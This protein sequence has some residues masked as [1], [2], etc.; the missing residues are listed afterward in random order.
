MSD[1]ISRPPFKQRLSV[2][3][4]FL[5]LESSGQ[6]CLCENVFVRSSHILSTPAAPES[7][8]LSLEHRA[9]PAGSGSGEP[10]APLGGCGPS[11]RALPN[12]FSQSRGPC[13]AEVSMLSGRLICV[14]GCYT[15]RNAG[16]ARSAHLDLRP[17]EQNCASRP[18]YRSTSRVKR[19][20][21]FR[22]YFL[23]IG[24]PSANAGLINVRVIGISF[25]IDAAWCTSPSISLLSCVFVL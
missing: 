13:S 24:S 6:S 11:E 22:V 14:G 3:T 1:P 25:G 7:F 9:R 21:P 19:F 8:R 18:G 4:G 16:R 12:S 2:P 5:C 10:H 15:S 20:P 23:G 17:P